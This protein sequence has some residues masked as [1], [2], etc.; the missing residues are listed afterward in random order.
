MSSHAEHSHHGGQPKHFTA[1]L[2]GLLILT[3]ITVGASYID[4]GPANTL[5]ALVIATAKATLVALFFMQL[6]WDKPVNSIIAVAGFLF[7]GILL[8]FTFLDL[9]TR[10]DPQPRNMPGMTEKQNPTAVPPSMSPRLTPPPAP[11]AAPKGEGGIEVE[12]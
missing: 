3:A 2:I 5:I 1:N 7:L 8:L 12:H 11:K 6:F 4:F 9:D 10:R